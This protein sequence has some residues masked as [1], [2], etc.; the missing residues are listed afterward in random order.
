MKHQ[1]LVLAALCASAATVSRAVAQGEGR[2]PNVLFIISDDLTASALSC[3]GNSQCKTPHIDAL[4]ERGTR[5]TRAYCQYPVCG[6][7]RASMMSGLFPETVEI[8]NN[9]SSSRIEKNLG[10]RPT[11]GQV[12][13]RANYFTARVSKIYHMLIPGDITR[14]VH[15]ADHPNSWNERYCFQAPEWNSVGEH[16]HLSNEKLITTGK[17]KHYSLGFGTAFYVVQAEGGGAEQIDVQATDKAIELLTREH[18]MPFFLALGLVRPHVPL[19]APASYFEPYPESRMLLPATPEDDWDDIPPAGIPKT[20][21]KFGLDSQEKK[22]KVL[23]AYYASVSFMDAQVG[24]ILAV[25]DNMGLRDNTIVVFTSDHGYHLGEH[26]FWQKSS[27]HEESA[28]IPLIIATPGKRPA[29]SS[30]LAQLMDLYPTLVEMCGLELPEHLQGRSLA[31][32]LNDPEARIHEFVHC[33]FGSQL[34][35]HHLIRTERH[36]YMAW[37]NGTAELYDMDDDPEQF[38]NLAGAEDSDEVLATLKG[39]LKSHLE[40]VAH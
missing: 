22:R 4:A 15:G 3:Y 32:V 38:T 9:S 40:Q 33:A 37:A 6:P 21:V 2:P 10:Q 39:H 20:S 12:F 30:S 17:N 28:R 8:L 7:S 26:E 23:Q 11:L 1:L 29:V 19:V 13:K 18:A 25:L 31:P 36:A 14:G 35:V 5:F 24:R 16:E 27:L 34:R